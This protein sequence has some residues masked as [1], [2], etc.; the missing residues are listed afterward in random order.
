VDEGRGNRNSIKFRKERQR[1]ISVGEKGKGRS[2]NLQSRP[3]REEKLFIDNQKRKPGRSAR[4]TKLRM[5]CVR[6]KITSIRKKKD[7][8]RGGGRQKDRIK[9]EKN[10][11]KKKWRAEMVKGKQR[12]RKITTKRK[13]LGR[14]GKDEKG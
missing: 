11:L 1:I 4:N 10:L 8:L 13:R 2:Q 7:K 12:K 3:K 14:A 5:G 9:K 6:R